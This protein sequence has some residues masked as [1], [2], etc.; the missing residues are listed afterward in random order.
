MGSLASRLRLALPRNSQARVQT[1]VALK[2]CIQTEIIVIACVPKE[3][4]ASVQRELAVSAC[5]QAEN[6]V[7]T[8]TACVQRK[9]A[10]ILVHIKSSGMRKRGGE[11]QPGSGPSGQ[12]APPCAAPCPLSKRSLPSPP[13]QTPQFLT[14]PAADAPG[15][16]KWPATHL[17][18]PGGRD[19]GH[20]MAWP[21]PPRRQTTG[22]Q[23]RAD[24]SEPAQRPAV[25]SAS[26]R[27]AS[28]ARQS[29]QPQCKSRGPIGERPSRRLEAKDPS[30][31]GRSRS[32]PCTAQDPDPD[33]PSCRR[34]AQ[35]RPLQRARA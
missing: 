30:E 9:I 3:I 23:R 4:T 5:V 22:Q 34:R 16:H 12:P 2:A 6:T 11:I 1:E 31:S 17:S 10:G 18:I 33:R 15:C 24:R 13:P 29:A 20:H 19:S 27:S 14:V 8:E 7:Q 21:G 25:Q 32:E 35:L 28:A 26:Q